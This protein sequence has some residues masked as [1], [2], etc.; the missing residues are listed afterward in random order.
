MPKTPSGKDVAP[1]SSPEPAS[2]SGAGTNSIAAVTSGTR[3][4][5]GW[6]RTDGLAPLKIPASSKALPILVQSKDQSQD[7]SVTPIYLPI[8]AP[9]PTS[10][11]APSP[12]SGGS[13]DSSFTFASRLSRADADAVPNPRD[14]LDTETETDE[15][16]DTD[17]AWSYASVPDLDWGL[18][19]GVSYDGSIG[20]PIRNGRQ[21]RRRRTSTGSV[22]TMTTGGLGRLARNSHR[23][24]RQDSATLPFDPMREAFFASLDRGSAGRRSR[25]NSE[26]RVSRRTSDIGNSRRGSRHSRKSG[27]ASAGVNMSFGGGGGK[28]CFC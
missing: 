28:W 15:Y 24:T 22:A 9:S 10:P 18:S 21:E 17:S 25:R 19:P 4:R 14:I 6:A 16:S 1:V 7:V 12:S 11:H 5:A 20:F 26:R 23:L 27:P 8:R 13:R 3:P 2:G